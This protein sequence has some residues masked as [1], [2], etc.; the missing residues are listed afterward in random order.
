MPAKPFAS[1]LVDFTRA[2][3]ELF[4]DM[5]DRWRMAQ[6][7]GEPRHAIV[8]D[9]GDRYEVLIAL[10]GVD[11][12]KLDIQISGR[13]LTVRVP[14]DMAALCEGSFAFAEPLQHEAVTAKATGG[15]LAIVLPKL[16]RSRRVRVE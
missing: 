2:F 13:T 1:T 6:G 3:D 11:P 4:D 8:R 15:T 9:Y 12:D 10:G 16:A 7:A 14:G 5:L